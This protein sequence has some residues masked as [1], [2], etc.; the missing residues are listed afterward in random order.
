MREEIAAMYGGTRYA[1]METPSS[2]PNILLFTDPEVGRENGYEFDGWSIDGEVFSYTGMGRVGPQKMQKGNLQTRDHKKLGKALRLFGVANKPS[3]K[4]GLPRV[5][6]G[7]FA[8]D[9]KQP[10]SVE[11]A[12]GVDG[13]MRTVFV[14]HLR[15]VGDVL[16]R[17]E[18]VTHQSVAPTAAG[19][20]T[21]VPM[22]KHEVDAFEQAA[23][24]AGIAEKRE[25]ALVA[26]FRAVLEGRGS[27]VNRHKVYPVGS[28][29]PLFTDIHDKTNG[30]LYEA[31]ADA[32]RH[33]VRLGLGQL[34]DYRRYVTG[35]SCRLLLPA[36]PDADL[37]KLLSEY[38]IDTVWRE[39]DGDSYSISAGGLV[40][41][42]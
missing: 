9:D 13:V 34:L 35:K 20:V 17:A 18:D 1:G 39:G 40:Q 12:P 21:E 25:L 2:S 22:E 31:K 14:F 6:L 38:Q 19:S 30:V 24:K 23:T 41:A 8:I 11:D 27:V 5:Y 42:F 4:G 10:Y 28:S 37:L 29:K 15:P 16:R 26:S 7:E 36:R 32:T 33:S 3:G